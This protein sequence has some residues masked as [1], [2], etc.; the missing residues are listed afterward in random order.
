MT[1]SFATACWGDYW[2]KFGTEFVASLAAMDPKPA[3]VVL[4]TDQDLYGPDWIRIVRPKS[5]VKMWDWFNEAVQACTSEWIMVGSVDDI[6]LPDGLAD[7]TLT[8]DLVATACLQNGELETCPSPEHWERLLDLD[9]TAIWTGAVF[10][11]E[12]FL[13]YPW[14]R[15]AYSDWM[16]W[17]ELRHAGASI[18]FDRKPRFVHR[19]HEASH[20]AQ[21]SEDGF[22]QIRTMKRWLAANLVTPGPEWPPGGK[23]ELGGGTRPRGDGFANMD[24]LPCA[25]IQHDLNSFPWPLADDSVCEV[26]SSHCLEHL[27]S[28]FPVFNELCRICRT[29]ALIELRVPHPMADLANCAGHMQVFSPLQAVNMETYF[30]RDFW[31]LPKRMKLQRIEYGASIYLDEAKRDMP[32][33][34]KY[35][36]EVVMKWIPR[37]CHECRFHYQIVENEFLQF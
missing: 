22:Q 37:T 17:L 13:R 1:I 29:G 33:L 19:R 4:V 28:P 10:R 25:D 18:T 35:P 12:L 26:Y 14:R 2:E 9:Q 30:P 32:F 3:E 6:M 11:R 20:T 27:P 5:S 31:K 8:G 23:L 15:V 16:Q 36:D 34:R 7:L 24:C 21:P